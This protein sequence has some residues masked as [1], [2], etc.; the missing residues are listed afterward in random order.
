[1]PLEAIS[2][3]YC[4]C[5]DGSDEPGTNAC[6]GLGGTFTC[7]RVVGIPLKVLPSSKVHDGV[8]DCCE[9]SDELE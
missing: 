9:G 5:A 3:N 4:D 8:C 7:A 6:A 2:D 1:I